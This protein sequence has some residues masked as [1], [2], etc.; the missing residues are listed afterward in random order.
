MGLALGHFI[1]THGDV[2][3]LQYIG[4]DQ[5]FLGNRPAAGGG[6]GH[7]QAV[8]A[9]TLQHFE[10]AVLD[11]HAV[12]ANVG[13]LQLVGALTHLGIGEVVAVIGPGQRLGF[14]GTQAQ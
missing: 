10:Q 3:V 1:A 2:E 9:Q 7:R 5:V 8:L 14:F 13:Q 12:I 6:H 4:I 11:R